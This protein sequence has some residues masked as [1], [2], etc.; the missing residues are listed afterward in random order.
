[1]GNREN[2]RELYTATNPLEDY[3]T[4]FDGSSRNPHR[5]KFCTAHQKTV[6]KEEKNPKQSDKVTR[7]PD[8]LSEQSHAEKTSDPRADYYTN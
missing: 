3:L 7:K 4:K 2:S 1:M 5:F 8:N 6:L